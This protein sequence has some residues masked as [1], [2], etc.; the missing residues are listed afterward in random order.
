M[1]ENDTQKFYELLKDFKT[2]MLITHAG[3]DKLRARPM[4]IAQI[5][6]NCRLWFLSGLET[7][8]THEIEADTHVHIVCQNDRTAYISLEGRATLVRN[9][10]KVE[11]L[12]NEAYRIWFPLGKDDPD[13]CLISVA[14]GEGEYWDNEGFNQI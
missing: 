5:E 9:R 8:K 1:P 6:P 13:I 10:A 12:W 11:E 4:A 14:P 3:N 7:A 2:A